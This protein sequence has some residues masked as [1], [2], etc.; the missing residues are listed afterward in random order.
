MKQIN[1]IALFGKTPPKEVGEEE[2]EVAA[3]SKLNTRLSNPVAVN[4][5]KRFV[6]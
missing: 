1:S 5:G 3:L 2:E 6:Q 4:T